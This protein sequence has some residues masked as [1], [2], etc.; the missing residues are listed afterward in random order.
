MSSDDWI[1][2]SA[3]VPPELKRF[4]DADERDNQDVIRSALWR[5][6]GGEKKAALDRRIEE[7]ENR[8][9]IVEREKNERDREVEDLKSD[10]E[11]LLAKRD[12]VE[13]KEESKMEFIDSR[14][15]TLQNVRGVVDETHPIVEALAR[16]HYQNDTMEALEAMRE[17]N[18]ELELVPEEYL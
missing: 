16:E 8:I 18:L 11:S 13:S 1:M 3:R 7:I 2:L 6:F 9:S 12:T 14:L 15:E 10:L 17:R 4:V 5:E